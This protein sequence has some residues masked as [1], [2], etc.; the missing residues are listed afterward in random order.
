MRTWQCRYLSKAPDLADQLLLGVMSNDQNICKKFGFA[1]G[2]ENY[3][4]LNFAAYVVLQKTCS[5]IMKITLVKPFQFSADPAMS[6]IIRKTKLGGTEKSHCLIA[7]CATNP[8]TQN[9]RNGSKHAARLAK[10]SSYL[11]I[12]PHVG[13]AVIFV[14]KWPQHD[15]RNKRMKCGYTSIQR[16]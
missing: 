11:K 7:R 13:S 10:A 1:K 4:Q 8:I 12:S 5:D 9:G 16:S 14:Q 6:G 3:F 2:L 15:G